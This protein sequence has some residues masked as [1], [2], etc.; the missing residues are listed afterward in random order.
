M[1]KRD[2]DREFLQIESQYLEMIQDLRDMEQEMGE[3]LVAPETYDQMKRMI[4]PI[5]VN[6]NTWNYIKF[7]LN[8]PA[9][10]EKEEK[11]KRQNKKLLANVKTLEQAKQENQKVLDDLKD[12]L[13]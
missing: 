5:L 2:F 8:K 12:Y 6:Y 4:D 13:R 3:G 7:I 10:K 1:S 9:R 11:Y